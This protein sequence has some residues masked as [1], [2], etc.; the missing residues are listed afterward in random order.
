MAEQAPQSYA[1]HTRLIPLYHFGC[2]GILILNLLW[3]IYLLYGALMAG[4]GRGDT[5][6][7]FLLAVALVILWLFAR[8][9]P[10]TAQDRVIR[11]EETLR[12]ER[13][14]PAPLKARIGEFTPAQLISLRFASDGELPDLAAK[15]LDGKITDRKVIKQMVKNWRPDNLRV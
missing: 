11:L 2:A 10:L 8:I 5:G 7:N 12:M 13:L 15:V 14:L 4:H 6:M 3:R 1:N 9:Q